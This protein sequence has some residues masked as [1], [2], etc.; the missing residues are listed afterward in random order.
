V[1]TLELTDEEFEVIRYAVAKVLAGNFPA[2]YTPTLTTL[3]K[4]FVAE[5]KLQRI[6]GK[7]D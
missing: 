3:I 6:G 2:K 1:I 5:L 7:N 4:K